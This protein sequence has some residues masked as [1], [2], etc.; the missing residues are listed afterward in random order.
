MLNVQ[1]LELSPDIFDLATLSR[2]GGYDE[3]LA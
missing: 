1:S 2:K 3:D